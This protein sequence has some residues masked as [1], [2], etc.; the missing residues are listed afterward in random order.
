M[1]ECAL[2][3]SAVKKFY[4]HVYCV[5]ACSASLL[6]PNNQPEREQERETGKGWSGYMH[7]SDHKEQIYLFKS[8]EN[9]NITLFSF[10]IKTK[11]E[12]WHFSQAFVI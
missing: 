1:R 5:Y 6:Y 12:F 11:F 7:K 2:D 9:I 8:I 10:H 3:Q 4:L